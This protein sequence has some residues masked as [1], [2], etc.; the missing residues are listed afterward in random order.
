MTGAL[1]KRLDPSRF[2]LSLARRAWDSVRGETAASF[3]SPFNRHDLARLLAEFDLSLPTADPR[4]ADDGVTGAGRYVLG[5]W[6]ERPALRRR[7]PIALSGPVDGPFETWLKADPTIRSSLSTVGHQNLVELLAARPFERVRQ[8]YELRP[9][10]REV[11]PLGLTPAQRGEYATWLFRYAREEY[12]L[13]DDEI[14]WYLLGLT[15]DSSCGLAVTYQLTPG[16]QR[17]IPDALTPAGW[18]S[19]RAW[20]GRTY[21]D[22]TGYWLRLATWPEIANPRLPAPAINV[23]GHFKYDSGL[24]EEA[25]QHVAALERSGYRTFL[26]DIPVSYPRDWRDGGRFTDME[27]GPITLIKT[28]AN[29]PLDEIYYRA[30]LHPRTGVYRIACWSWELE[31]FPQRAVE[32]GGLANEVWT[33]S[34]FCARSVRVAMP[35]RPVFAMPPAVTLPEFRPQTRGFFGLPAD[36]FLFLFMFD[37]ASGMER[38]NPLGLIRA[39]RR[40][41]RAGE[42]VD[43]AIKVSRGSAYPNEFAELQRLA[44]AAGVTLI[45]R[46]MPR[47]EVCSLLATCDAYVSLHRSEGFGFTMAEAMLLGKPTIATGYSGNLDFMTPDD[48][49]LV[50]YDRL[51]LDRDY[52]PYPVGCVWAGPS[53]EHA[54]ELLR[55]VYKNQDE[56]AVVARRGRERVS[57]FLSREAA[58]QRITTRLAEIPASKS[59]KFK[60]FKV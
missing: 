10:V 3:F 40:A 44:E 21:P 37:M 15:E 56:A 36:R 20:V 38:K 34:E 32:R 2:L 4:Q 16:W 51:T 39:F 54:A 35:G 47:A 14:L 13:R 53:E 29:D 50:R 31:A 52:P 48:S 43:L 11:F 19:L 28:G 30:G 26:R 12:G 1:R 41:F 60:E 58:A 49:Y 27:T 5:L 45:D 22:R 59:L 7:F 33:P 9:D 6:W 17:A 24:Q 18:E 42:P 46:V 8:V 23:L 55:R 25:L 57:R